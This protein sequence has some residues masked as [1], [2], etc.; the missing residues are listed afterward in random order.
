MAFETISLGSL[1]SGLGGDT[2]RSAFE[3]INRNLA[4]IKDRALQANYSALSGQLYR[5]VGIAASSA[6]VTSLTIRTQ[7]PAISGIAPVVRLQG[8][9][10]TYTSPVTLDLSWYFYNGVVSSAFGLLDSASP[11]IAT[12]ASATALQV[13]LYAE[14]GMANL[15]VK[16]PKAVYYPRLAVSCLHTGALPMGA[17]TETGWEVA[18]DAPAPAASLVQAAFKLTTTLNTANCK[19]G[20]DGTIKVA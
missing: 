15:Y 3:K 4:Q 14:G 12:L 6:N 5:E 9:L 20:N 8:C 11:A 17:G 2:A 16:F 7:V 10:D 13:V 1:P 18:F 19:V